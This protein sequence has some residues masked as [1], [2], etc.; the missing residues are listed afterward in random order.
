MDKT[1]FENVTFVLTEGSTLDDECDRKIVYGVKALDDCG[2][3]L[4]MMKDLS[5]DKLSVENFVE[6]CNTEGVLP[7]HVNDVLRDFALSFTF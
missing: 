3:I 2:K 1:H 6:L 4:A 5:T 7:D